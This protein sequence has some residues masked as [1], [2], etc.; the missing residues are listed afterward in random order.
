MQ[1]CMYERKKN[2]QRTNKRMN[3][4]ANE[5]INANLYTGRKHLRTKVT[6]DLHLIYSKNWE[7][8]GWNRNNKKRYFSIFLHKIICCGCVLESPRRGDSNEELRKQH[9]YDLVFCEN[10]MSTETFTH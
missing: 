5:L 1:E 9:S 4:Q 7:T 3:E 2:D 10:L 8:W 6:P